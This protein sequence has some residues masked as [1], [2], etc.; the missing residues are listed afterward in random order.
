MKVTPRHSTIRAERSA[1]ITDGPILGKGTRTF[2][3]QRIVIAYLWNGTR[4]TMQH[5]DIYGPVIK[6]DGTPGLVDARRTYWPTGSLPE[7]TGA[8]IE[9]LRPVGPPLTDAVE[10]EVTE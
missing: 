4:W 3:A 8:I 10:F 7:W 2:R 5:T 1:D 6:K 9:A